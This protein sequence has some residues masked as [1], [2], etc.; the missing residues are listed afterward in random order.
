MVVNLRGLLELGS[1]RISFDDREYNE[2][3]ITY[4]GYNAED[5]TYE[6]KSTFRSG[7]S[8]EYKIIRTKAYKFTIK[9]AWRIEKGK[10]EEAQFIPISDISWIE[11]N[12][13][14]KIDPPK[15]LGQY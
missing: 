3:D 8:I 2:L 15:P 9:E 13:E 1:G 10:R 14:K 12:L 11:I 7:Y 4:N 6:V 5:N